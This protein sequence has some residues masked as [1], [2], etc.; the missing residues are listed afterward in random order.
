M[1]TYAQRQA[2]KAGI[3]FVPLDNAF[4]HG[5]HKTSHPETGQRHNQ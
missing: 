5:T 1:T 4:Y 2:A 3:G